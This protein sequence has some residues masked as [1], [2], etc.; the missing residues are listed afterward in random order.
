MYSS[1]QNSFLKN[2]KKK[3]CFIL[4]TLKQLLSKELFFKCHGNDAAVHKK[5]FPPEINS[6][7]LSQRCAHDT[8]SEV[9]FKN[10]CVV[11]VCV[12]VHR[13]QHELGG[14]RTTSLHQMDSSDQTQVVRFSGSQ[15]PS[16]LSH[17]TDLRLTCWSLFP[18]TG[19]CHTNTTIE[20]H[21]P[22]W[23]LSLLASCSIKRKHR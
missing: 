19:A 9:I 15:H 8:G 16:W 2:K 13:Y 1:L 10:M 22:S 23:I 20:L 21:P 12:F 18:G 5:P 14:L 11:S 17:L 7:Y 4:S 3:S 6:H